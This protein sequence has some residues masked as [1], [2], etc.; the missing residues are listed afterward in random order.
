MQKGDYLKPHMHENGWL[1][2]SIY[3][4]FPNFIN[5]MKV[6]LNFL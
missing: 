2:G 3:L 5:L 6:V 4:N 1:S